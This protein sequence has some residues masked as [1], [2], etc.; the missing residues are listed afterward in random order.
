MGTQLQCCVPGVTVGEGRGVRDDS[1]HNPLGWFQPVPIVCDRS[2]ADGAAERSAGTVTGCCCCCCFL[3][4]QTVQPIS[5]PVWN[6]LY[7]RS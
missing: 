1:T 7:R 5:A 2:E 6:V 3:C 4:Q